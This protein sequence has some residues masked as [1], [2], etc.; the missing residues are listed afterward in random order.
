MTVALLHDRNQITVLAANV[1]A[2]EQTR[3]RN[4]HVLGPDRAVRFPPL[5]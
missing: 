3:H 5:Q 2:N 1:L 4:H